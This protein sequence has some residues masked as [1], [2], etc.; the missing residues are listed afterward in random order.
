VSHNDDVRRDSEVWRTEGRVVGRV[1]CC[2]T[3]V[4]KVGRGFEDVEEV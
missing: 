4:V 2:A 3:V 1:R